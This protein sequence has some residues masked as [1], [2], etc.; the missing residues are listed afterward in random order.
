MT[1]SFKTGV[2]YKTRGG[3]KAWYVGES[4][5]PARPLV[6]EHERSYF[7]EYTKDG[8][9][10]AELFPERLDIIGLWEDEPK[11]EDMTAADV[12]ER[13]MQTLCNIK[14]SGDALDAAEKELV[15]GATLKALESL[16]KPE[17]IDVANMWVGIWESEGQLFETGWHRDVGILRDRTDLH[18]I[19][20]AH[21]WEA[22][23]RGER[24]LKIGEGL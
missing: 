17:E 14:R 21:E 5:N 18:T 9:W 20:R 8:Y 11:G 22:I 16:K 23:K 15:I 4:Q 3:E 10:D 19:I 6:F 2:T 13:W 1:H 12:D 7:R 24:K